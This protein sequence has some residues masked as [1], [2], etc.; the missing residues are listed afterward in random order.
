MNQLYFP[1]LLDVFVL[2]PFQIYIGTLV[3]NIF[4]KFVMIII[5]MSSI[6]FNGHNFLC[7]DLQHCFLD[8]PY[9]SGMG[10]YQIHRLY[11]LLIMYPLMYQVTQQPEL[12]NS[13]KLLLL[14]N[15]IIGF[16]YN[17]FYYIYYIPIYGY[18]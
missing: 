10:K 18:I 3:K 5:G 13:N 17:L 1:R 9:H 16:V 6:I 4:L 12:S 14:L 2:G 11:N 7:I 8:Y 15:I